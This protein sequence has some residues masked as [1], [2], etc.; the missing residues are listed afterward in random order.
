M[1]ALEL[2]DDFTITVLEARA[3][4]G[5]R[6]RSHRSSVAP[7]V[8]ET[9]AE[10]IHGKLPLTFKLLKKADIERVVVKGK[11]FRKKKGEWEKQ[12]EFIEGWDAVL[13]NMRSLDR[14][15]TMAEFL[16]LYYNSEVHEE[17]RRHIK[18]YAE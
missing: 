11:F 2:A 14:D 7:I 13:G 18:S 9:G 5:G 17:L 1:A 10:F 8:I 6:I 3:A 4:T 16:D 15:M 12:N